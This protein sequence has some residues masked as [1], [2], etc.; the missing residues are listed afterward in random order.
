MKYWSRAKTDAWIQHILQRQRGTLP[1]KH[2]FNWEL[3][4]GTAKQG[5]QVLT[6][7]T[8]V[9]ETASCLNWTPKEL[10]YAEKVKTLSNSNHHLYKGLPYA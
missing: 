9:A 2:H 10:L 8:F 7:V 5:D 3:L 6:Q 1:V 4:P